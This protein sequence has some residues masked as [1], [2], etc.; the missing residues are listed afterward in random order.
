M[1]KKSITEALKK[2]KQDNKK[3]K[4]SQS[5][6]FVANFKDIDLKKTDQHVDYFVQLHHPRGK[7]IKVCALVDSE[8][9]E[10]AKKTCDHA[11]HL[12]DFQKYAKDKKAAKK[13]AAEY[14]FFIAQANIMTKVA[15]TFGRV[16]GPRGR[17]PNPKAG[18]VVPPK[19]NLKP[20][21][22]KL[23]NTIKVSVKVT[24]MFMCGLGKEDQDEAEVIDNIM[25]LYNS[26]I[27]HLPKEKNNI[28]KMFLKLTMSKAIEVQ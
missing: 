18:C 17:M 1:D 26:L 12:D 15:A 27:H 28:K 19:A 22:D 11:I 7:K 24:P 25:T 3:R 13:L 10:D 9:L 21:Y 6:D 20:L 16:F 23:Q 2:L 5:I 4:F 14:D 8:L